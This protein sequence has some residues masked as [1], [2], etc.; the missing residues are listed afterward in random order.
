MEPHEIKAFLADKIPN[1]LIE[2]NG[3]DCD[4]QITIVS[5]IFDSMPAVKRQQAVYAHLTPFITSGSIHA[6][7]MQTFTPQE[8]EQRNHR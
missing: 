2:I 3:A 5:E 7:S 8:W 4:L 6:L 1:A